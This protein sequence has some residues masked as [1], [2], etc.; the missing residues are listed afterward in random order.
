M[1]ASTP[2]PLSVLHTVEYWPCVLLQR[3]TTFRMTCC[4]YLYEEDKNTVSGTHRINLPFTGLVF[5][6]SVPQSSVG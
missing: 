2:F 1:R 3:L 5:I 4:Y 6:F